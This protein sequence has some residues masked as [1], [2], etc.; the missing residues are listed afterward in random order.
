MLCRL[1]GHRWRYKNYH[2]SIQANGRRYPFIATRVCGRCGMKQIKQKLSKTWSGYPEGF[3][4]RELLPRESAY[5][6]REND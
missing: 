2:Y 4:L 1:I 5:P 3:Q 6:N